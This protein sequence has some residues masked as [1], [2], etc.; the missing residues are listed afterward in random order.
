M[1][2]GNLNHIAISDEFD[3]DH[4]QSIPNGQ[5]F[6]AYLASWGIVTG[7]PTDRANDN[8]DGGVLIQLMDGM[9]ALNENEGSMFYNKLKTDRFATIGRSYG[10]NRAI[11]AAAKRRDRVAAVISDAQCTA[12]WCTPTRE[13]DVSAPSL[14]V[15]GSRD[16]YL[17][18][19][20]LGYS[21]LSVPKQLLIAR[22]RTHDSAPMQVWRSWVTLFILLH[23][24]GDSEFG[25]TV[26]GEAFYSTPLSDRQWGLMS[27]GTYRT[28]KYLNYWPACATESI[29]EDLPRY[30]SCPPS[31][32]A[33]TSV[34]TVSASS[35]RDVD[36]LPADMQNLVGSR[37]VSVSRRPPSHIDIDE[38]SISL[39]LERDSMRQGL[40]EFLT[41]EGTLVALIQE[42][43]EYFDLNDSDNFDGTACHVL[44]TLTNLG[45]MCAFEDDGTVSFQPEFEALLFEI[46]QL[47]DED[48][49]GT[50][51]PIE[52]TS[53]LRRYRT[54][55]SAYKN[56]NSAIDND[57]MTAT[58]SVCP[59]YDSNSPTSSIFS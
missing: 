49:D 22:G 14:Y 15:I 16:E 19:V 24:N 13:N 30:D 11:N 37:Y 38:S 40:V 3:T 34:A 53:T 35:S 57:I 47:V 4:T 41:R 55:R 39:A 43:G 31:L 36:D 54:A 59:T 52:V 33:T 29:S 56:A 45:D 27:I 7:C 2:Y 50:V 5:D 23:V 42:V 9:T 20:Q 17:S 12:A 25:S 44:Q 18:G 32:C 51:T 28:S 1:I 46:V 10:G 21:R 26:W 6:M 8:W 48:E 58:S